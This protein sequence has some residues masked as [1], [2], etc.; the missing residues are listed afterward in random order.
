MVTEK[1]SVLRYNHTHY[2]SPNSIEDVSDIFTTALSY[3]LCVRAT[4]FCGNSGQDGA[5]VNSHEL[6]SRNVS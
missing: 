4:T 5:I 6:T 2:D 1:C 3:Y